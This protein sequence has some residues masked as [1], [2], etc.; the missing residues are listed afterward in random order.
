V[1]QTTFL[2]RVTFALS[3]ALAPVPQVEKAIAGTLAPSITE[4]ECAS[5]RS[6]IAKG[7]KLSDDQQG[8]F[9]QCIN[10]QTNGQ[11]TVPKTTDI[12]SWDCVQFFGHKACDQRDNAS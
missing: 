3:S 4:L 1:R 10:D 5:I 6:E 8:I 12:P 2:L 11:I 9:A 7:H